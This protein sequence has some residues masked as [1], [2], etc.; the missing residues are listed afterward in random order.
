MSFWQCKGSG[1][2]GA[3]LLFR[4]LYAENGIKTGGKVR[5]K[6]HSSNLFG[7]FFVKIAK[8]KKYLYSGQVS[9]TLVFVMLENLYRSL[10]HAPMAL[11]RPFI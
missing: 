9:K 2:S 4:F 5:Y 10:K 8:F 1:K 6:I 11:R 3:L 7:S